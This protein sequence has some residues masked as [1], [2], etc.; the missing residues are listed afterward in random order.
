MAS[1]AIGSLFVSLGLDT[2]VFTAGVKKVQ[3]VTGKLQKSFA[4]FGTAA[5][6]LGTK[7]SV[8]SAGMAAVGLAGAALVKQTADAAVQIERQAKIANASTE[9][10]QRWS[11]GAK[12]AGIDQDKL[13]DIL[14]DVNDRVGDFLQ[15]GGGPMADFFEK[16][17]PKVGVTAEQFKNLSG[18][19]ALQLY[20]DT[21][22]KAGMSQQDMT[23]YMEAMASDATALLPLLLNGGKAMDAYG[24]AAARSGAVM[25]E[26]LIAASVQFNE[27]LNVLSERLTGARN[28]LA[29][30]LLPVINRF[31]DVLIAKGVPALE[32]FIGFVEKAI[33]WF[34][35]L[36]GPVQEAAGAIAAVLGTGG[37]ILLAI[38][39]LSKAFAALMT[40]AVG[41]IAVF[42]GIAVIAYQAWQK[43]GTEIKAAVGGAIDYITG[44][45][46]AFV[47][48]LKAII[49]WAGKVKTAVAEALQYA[50][51]GEGGFDPDPYAN[52]PQGQGLINGGN[53]V[54]DLD[55][56]AGADMLTQ[57]TEIGGNLA[58]GI[59][60]GL[61]TGLQT[62]APQIQAAINTVPAIARSEL[63]IQSPSRVFM[64]IGNFITQGLGL[65]ISQGTPQ[66]Q[67]AMTGVS[68]AV[69]GE[70][71]SMSS[72]MNSFASTAQGAFKSVIDGSKTVGDALRELAATWI[73]SIADN[74]FNAGWNGIM[75]AI[76]LP[77]NA[78]GTRDWRG[79]LT[80]VNE[81]GGE[82]MN[83]PKGTQIIPNDIS[84][85][86]ADRSGGGSNVN[87]QVVPSPMFQVVVREEAANVTREGISQYDRQMPDRISSITRDGR[88]RS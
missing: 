72:S 2:A 45:F 49:E 87:V 26:K 79:G 17:A 34:A 39:V 73:S 76:G 86:M 59:T 1:Q 40:P 47:A 21:L 81:R 80:R 84:K 82:I 41:P 83:L 8:V 54:T 6:N 30:V 24:D 13:A 7:L 37:P 68:D 88:K 64:E 61:T 12:R 16:V 51:A 66:V 85:R 60:N 25:S 31:L 33:Q 10:F 32:K 14:K 70:S 65:G 22:Q 46:D 44:K 62:A 20:V 55:G 5:T 43:W 52:T 63:G 27:K 11:A 9:E 29:E 53:G 19:D 50:P 18:P 3:G 35:D 56:S 57:G 69:I 42:I 78:N 75:G 58:T 36:P 71:D 38:G 15:T 77:T 67:G 23:F 74:M 28:Q 48:K 4:N